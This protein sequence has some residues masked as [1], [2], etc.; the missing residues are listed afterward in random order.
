MFDDI[1]AKNVPT[2][3]DLYAGYDDGNWPDAD[4]LAARFPGLYIVRITVFPWDNEGLVLDVELGD[5]TPA[6]APDWLARR[7]AAG[8]WPTLYVNLGN[9]SQTAA[10]VNAAGLA[11]PP[12]WVA[13]YPSVLPFGVPSIPADWI[14]KGVVAWQYQSTSNYDVS[15]VAD[16]WPGIDPPAQGSDDV[17]INDDDKREYVRSLVQELWGRELLSADE[18]NYLVSYLNT[19][20]K[21]LTR[22]AVYDHQNA[23]DL[24]A[25]RGW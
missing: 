11:Q 15:T 12:Y 7:R 3:G 16:Y 13:Y 1:F 22:A 21:D 6:Q 25:R 14:A 4:A 5:A 10:A 17:L 24:R 23:Q 20:G 18:Q 8:A 2:G 19:N 9:W